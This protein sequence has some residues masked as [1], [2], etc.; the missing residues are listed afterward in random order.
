MTSL[1]NLS[2]TI[3]ITAF[4]C[5]ETLETAVF[6]A[7]N[8]DHKN[9]EI[10]I[11]DDCSSDN[12]N[13]IALKLMK[14]N[15]KIR[16]FRATKNKGVAASRNTIIKKASSHFIAFFDDD[17]I[18]EPNRISTQ[19]AA[20]V[21][22]EDGDP[23]KMVICHSA[24]LVDYPIGISRYQESLAQEAGSEGVTGKLVS[25]A[26]LFGT[27]NNWLKG[28]CPTCSQMARVRTYRMLR[29]FDKNL[30]RSEDT[31]LSIRAAESGA[32]FIGIKTPLVH[33][34]MTISSDKN[35]NIEKENWM[36]IIDKHRKIIERRMSYSFAVNWLTLRH[37]WLAKDFA[38]FA[39]TLGKLVLFSPIQTLRK[40]C[41]ALPNT[42]LNTEMSNF[43]NHNMSGANK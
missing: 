3:G 22:C 21:A 39:V 26:I 40:L 41:L 16:V 37:N 6:S 7:L 20:L 28:A 10:L 19:L 43:H 13:L 25:E 32:T 14:S 23:K 30:R 36:Y 5:E 9:T 34:R 24:R 8:Q 33:Q 27:R 31:E 15:P 38:A 42:Q 35:L 17:D 29:G 2:V 18:S 12:T 1:E 4:N 11:V